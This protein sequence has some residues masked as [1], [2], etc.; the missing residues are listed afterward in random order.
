V[1]KYPHFAVPGPAIGFLQESL[2]WWDQWLKGLDSGIMAEPL[3]RAYLMDGAP[4]ASSYARRDG[5]WIAEETWPS[6][7][8]EARAYALNPGRIDTAAGPEVALVHCSP[9]DVGSACGEYCAM[10]LGPEWPGEQRYDD[11]GSLAFDGAPLAET[12]ELLGAPVAQLELACDKPRGL[13]VARLCD[14]APDGASTRITYGVLNLCHRHGHETPQVLVPGERIAVSLRLDDVAYAVAPGHR[15]RLAISTSYWPLIWP[16]PEP[17]AITLFAGASRLVLPE[18]APVAGGPRPFE[19]PEGAAPLDAEQLRPVAQRRWL[20]RDLVSGESRLVIV[21]DLGA[22][23]IRAHGLERGSVCR[24]HY[25]ILPGDPLS[26][27]AEISWT[28]TLGRGDW[29]IRTES[30]HEQSADRE[31]FHLRAEIRAFEGEQQVFEK[32]WQRSVPRDFL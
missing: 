26:A 31:Q 4:P 20:E 24:E 5:R 3:Y 27:R 11:A 9:Q 14:V 15:L 32:G 22:Q 17:A 12:L 1:H 25:R 6:P 2:R 30:R 18:R 7:S 10:W 28:Q 8:V 23:R 29:Q 19:P 13:L 21:D 16:S